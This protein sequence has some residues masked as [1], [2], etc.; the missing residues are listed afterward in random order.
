MAGSDRFSLILTS[1]IG[2]VPTQKVRCNNKEE[3]TIIYLAFTSITEEDVIIPI[4]QKRFKKVQ[5]QLH[6]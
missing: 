5:H 2:F 1:P 4:S 3:W 6:N